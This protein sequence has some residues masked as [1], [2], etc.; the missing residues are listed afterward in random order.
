MNCMPEP[1]MWAHDTGQQIPSLT[2][3]SIMYACHRGHEPLVH[4]TSH[5]DHE[6]TSYG[7]WFSMYPYGS[8]YLVMVPLLASSTT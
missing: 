2:A 6:I 7:K 5:V 8:I 4:A 1:M 3:A